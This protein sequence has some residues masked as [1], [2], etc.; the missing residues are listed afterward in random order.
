LSVEDYWPVSACIVSTA[1][2]NSR[3]LAACIRRQSPNYY[4]YI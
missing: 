2:G 3:Q 4:E 1:T